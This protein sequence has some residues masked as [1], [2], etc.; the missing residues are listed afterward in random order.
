MTVKVSVPRPGIAVRVTGTTADVGA[1]SSQG[2]AGPSGAGYT[3]TQGTASDTWAIAHNL[4]FRPN[5]ALADASG[6]AVLGSIHHYS[7]NVVIVTFA[8]PLAGSARLT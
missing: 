5:V 8:A 2:P 3:H 4:G 7:D 1:G 6:F